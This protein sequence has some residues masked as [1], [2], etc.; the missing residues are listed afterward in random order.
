MIGGIRNHRYDIS[1]GT[2]LGRVRRAVAAWLGLLLLTFN[3]VGGG[4]LPAR[5]A[6]DGLAPFAQ[7]IFGDRIVICTAA[8]MVV[9]DRNGN[10]V[11][12]E[13]GSGHGELCAFCLPLMHGGV[14]APCVLAIVA[15]AAALVR[16]STIPAASSFARPARLAG[17][18]A[19][20]APPLA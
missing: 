15:P 16:S 6:E 3:V 17:T 18:A 9:L 10:P 5:S 11:S 20:R 8:G 19:P 12:P 1:T 2:P 7:E 4:A 14:N 13:G